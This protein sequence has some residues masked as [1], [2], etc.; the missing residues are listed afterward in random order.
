MQNT[1]NVTKQANG[2]FSELINTEF[3]SVIFQRVTE[4][5][6]INAHIFY[7][8][9]II[10]SNVTL[11]IREGKKIQECKQLVKYIFFPE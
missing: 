2:V 9:E 5:K 3:H 7:S 4:V 6:I 8:K 10:Y 1:Y 11:V